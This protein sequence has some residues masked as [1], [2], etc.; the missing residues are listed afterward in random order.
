MGAK[1]APASKL[2]SVDQSLQ[3]G[4]R[5]PWRAPRNPYLRQGGVAESSGEEAEPLRELTESKNTVA[6]V[7]GHPGKVVIP[8]EVGRMRQDVRVYL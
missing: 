7:L 2:N 5:R 3:G 4:L 1:V 8:E 6:V